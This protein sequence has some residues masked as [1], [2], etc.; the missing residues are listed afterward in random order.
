MN[1]ELTRGMVA[2]IDDGDISLIVGYSWY[3]YPSKHGDRILTW[4]A[5]TNVKDSTGDYA[6]LSMHILL[7]SPVEGSQVDHKNGNGL[8]NRRD[9]LR[10]C[11]P[12]Q[13]SQNKRKRFNSASR[14]KCVWLDKKTGTW[15][16]YIRVCGRLITIGKYATEEEAA[17]AYDYEAMKNFGE[18]ARLN[19]PDDIPKEIKR[20][21]RSDGQRKRRRI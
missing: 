7:V 11:T 10:V 2:T 16:A 14:F 1:I 6:P 21:T 3:A 5:G 17:R 4:Y 13:N 18:F 19:F 9:N 8:D 20:W 12:S 15:R